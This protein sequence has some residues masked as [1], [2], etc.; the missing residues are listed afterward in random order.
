[1][2][3]GQDLYKGWVDRETT[4]KGTRRGRGSPPEKQKQKKW[5]EE[6]LAQTIYR[7]SKGEREVEISWI[8]SGGKR[9]RTR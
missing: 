4:E 2:E 1:M 5:K 6:K 3:S 7:K 8:D 9:R